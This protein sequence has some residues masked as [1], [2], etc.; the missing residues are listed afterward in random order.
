[1]I[2]TQADPVNLSHEP[3]YKKKLQQTHKSA[4]FGHPTRASFQKQ[5]K[6]AGNTLQKSIKF[7]SRIFQKL[8]KCRLRDIII[9]D[10]DD[11]EIKKG[12]FFK[13]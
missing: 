2:D 11:D 10:D 6:T 12:T 1:M 13:I 7:L 8:D 4:D 9:M 3:K 5:K